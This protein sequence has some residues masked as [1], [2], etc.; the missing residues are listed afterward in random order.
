[1]KAIRSVRAQPPAV[2]TPSLRASLSHHKSS[3]ISFRPII[4]SC[5]KQPE[6]MEQ[7]DEKPEQK[8]G[9]VMSESFGEGYATRSDEE[10]FGGIYGENESISDIKKHK[11]VHESHPAYDKTQGSEVKEKE[12]ARN[13]THASS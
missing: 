4:T 13:Q 5:S 3:V 1:M 8:P 10:G 7:K 2:F 12:K 11:E 9:D 6:S